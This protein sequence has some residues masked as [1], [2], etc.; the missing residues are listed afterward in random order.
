MKVNNSKQYYKIP[1][2]C[3]LVGQFLVILPHAF[4]KM[5]TWKE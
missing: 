5:M 3:I 1:F 2:K 4:N